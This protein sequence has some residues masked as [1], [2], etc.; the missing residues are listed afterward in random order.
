MHTKRKMKRI[1]ALLKR[2]LRQSN[3]GKRYFQEGGEAFDQAL[4]LGAPVDEPITLRGFTLAEDRKSLVFVG[5]DVEATVVVRDHLKDR[6]GRE[7]NAGF[8]NARFQRFRV[9]PFR[10]P[11]PTPTPRAK[12][13]AP[14]EPAAEPAT[15][16]AVEV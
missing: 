5:G 2:S 13:A 15:P 1:A 11:K 14:A 4:A 16:V 8:T 7:I 10:E 6:D 12:K 3:R 9:E